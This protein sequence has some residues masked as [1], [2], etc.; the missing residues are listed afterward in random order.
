[1]KASPGVSINNP[2]NEKK[3]SLLL[4]SSG[5]EFAESIMI[6]IVTPGSSPRRP[7]RR[8]LELQVSWMPSP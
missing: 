5:K 1:M 4:T 2:I 6:V 3:Q 8:T 7:P